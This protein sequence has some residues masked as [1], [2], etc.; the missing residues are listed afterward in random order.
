LCLEGMEPRVV[1][2]G[3]VDLPHTHGL[4]AVD[5]LNYALRACPRC[6]SP[7]ASLTRAASTSGCSTRNETIAGTRTSG[8]LR[9]LLRRNVGLA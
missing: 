9:R 6:S 7:G 2:S 4:Q 3:M 5:S 1:E 8:S